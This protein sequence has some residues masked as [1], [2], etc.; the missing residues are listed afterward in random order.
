MKAFNYKLYAEANDFPHIEL[1][2]FV[3]RLG[4]EFATLLRTLVIRCQVVQSQNNFKTF[5]K[6]LKYSFPI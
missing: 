2:S 3:Q 6:V 5:F 4:A 1:Q